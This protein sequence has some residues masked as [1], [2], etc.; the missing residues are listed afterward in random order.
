MACPR[1]NC[2]TVYQYDDEDA[3]DDRWQRCAACGVV[4]DLY[5]HTDEDEDDE[6]PTDCRVETQAAS[7]GTD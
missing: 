1:C 5:D 6:R 7:R 2:K 3:P 4:F